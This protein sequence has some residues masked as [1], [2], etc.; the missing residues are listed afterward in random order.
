MPYVHSAGTISAAG[1]A[2]RNSAR[3]PFAAG[4]PGNFPVAVWVLP[5]VGKTNVDG[6]D[7]GFLAIAGR[8]V[9]RWW[10]R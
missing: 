7:G 9:G 4:I 8:V 2:E 10:W 6:G 5:A 3:L 1:V